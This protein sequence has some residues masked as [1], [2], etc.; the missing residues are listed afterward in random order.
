MLEVVAPL[1]RSH[2]IRGAVAA[3]VHIH[4]WLF[5]APYNTF[6]LAMHSPY[7]SRVPT[8]YSRIAGFGADSL[9]SQ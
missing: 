9:V 8:S 7:T 1:M 2:Y 3:S 5:V 6:A 4:F